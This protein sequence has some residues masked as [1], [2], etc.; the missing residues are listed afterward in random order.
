MT[1]RKPNDTTKKDKAFMICLLEPINN[2]IC[3][4]TY[5]IEN[6]LGLLKKVKNTED[7]KEALK[8][9]TDVSAHQLTLTQHLVDTV[10]SISIEP[11]GAPKVH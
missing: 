8:I 10:R 7:F 11:E 2:S 6:L 1:T 3:N 4:T 9:L 5:D